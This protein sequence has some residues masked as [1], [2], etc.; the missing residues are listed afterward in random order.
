MCKSKVVQINGV[1]CKPAKAVKV[2][3]IITISY[4]KGDQSFEVLQIPQ[5]K[6]IPKSKKD[7]YVKEL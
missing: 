2:G 7:E 4:L 3:D 6:S 1:V 5:S